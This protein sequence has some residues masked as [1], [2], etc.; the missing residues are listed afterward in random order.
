[1]SRLGT[2]PARIDRFRSRLA[3]LV[4][5][6]GIF[7]SMLVAG[8]APAAYAETVGTGNCVMIKT[9]TVTEITSSVGADG[10]TSCS[11]QF[12]SSGSFQ[13]P[14]GVTSLNTVVI[15]GGGGGGAARGGGG[16]GGGV[17][18]SSGVTATAGETFSL[19]VAP[20]GAGGTN[21]GSGNSGNDSW[22]ARGANSM[23]SPRIAQGGGGG[24]GGANR[25]RGNIDPLRTSF[26]RIK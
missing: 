1:M 23:T 9:G 26:G 21:S 15:G 5:T 4:A 19:I 12:T 17:A 24:G 14:A 8:G 22:L 2:R 18:I 6:T 11:Y 10:K 7:T 16:G 20:G 25:E 3:A 13:I